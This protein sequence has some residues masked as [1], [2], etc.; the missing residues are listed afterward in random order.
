MSNR[1]VELVVR[2]AGNPE[3][4]LFLAPGVTHLGR[5][6]D[7][8]LVLADIGVSRRHARIIVN[9]AQVRYEDLGSGNGSFVRGRRVDR[10]VVGSGDEVVIDP[11]QLTFR[12]HGSRGPVPEDDETVRAPEADALESAPGRLVVLAGHRL[13][14]AYPVTAAPLSLGRS[15][16]RDVV[17]FDPAASRDHASIEMRADGFWLIDRGSANGT[18]VNELRVSGSHQLMSGDR[19]RIGATEF[20]FELSGAPAPALAAPPPAAAPP[21]MVSQPAMPAAPPPVAAP[22]PAPAPAPVAAPM[23]TPMAPPPQAP[24]ARI[25]AVS[26]P[27]PPPRSRGGLTI[28]VAVAGFFIVALGGAAVVGGLLYWKYGGVNLS[29]APT[30]PGVGEAYSPTP[31]TEAEVSRLLAHGAQHAGQGRYLE[32]ASK[33]YKI[34]KIDNG[35]PE[36][37]W[38]G[39]LACELVAFDVLSRDLTSRD[40]DE[41]ALRKEVRAA[42]VQGQKAIEGDGDLAVAY[43]VVLDLMRKLPDNTELSQMARRLQSAAAEFVRSDEGKKLQKSLAKDIERGFE[44]I[45]A[46]DLDAARSSFEEVVDADSKRQTP[47]YYRAQ[48]GLRL[49]EVRQ[50]LGG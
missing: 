22:A 12:F 28:L 16:V 30:P 6:E 2:R 25:R 49:V 26:Q 11:F 4:R 48:E 37:R 17:L 8:D 27:P 19:V 40:V 7:N 41:R 34:H 23:P 1:Q 13:A 10:H 31:G 35:H 21:P 20:R 46:G 24:P 9:D 44:A 45:D 15:E 14:A 5:A 39:Y 18:Y 3:Q 38:R 32:A 36:A 43:D 33:Y 50:H 29:A 47:Q 42:L